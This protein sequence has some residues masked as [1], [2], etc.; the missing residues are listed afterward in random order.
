VKNKGQNH[1]IKK[2]RAKLQ[3]HFKAGKNT[4]KPSFLGKTE[5]L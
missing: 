3:L 2:M 4:K 5:V 1:K